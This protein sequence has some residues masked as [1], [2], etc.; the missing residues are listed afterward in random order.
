MNKQAQSLLDYLLQV[1][2]ELKD[3]KFRLVLRPHGKDPN[4]KNLY[5]LWNDAS[6]RIA[7]RKFRR[8]PNMSEAELKSLVSAGLV[9]IHGKELK[10]TSHGVVVLRKMI[11]EDDKFQLGKKAECEECVVKTASVEVSPNTWYK[12]YRDANSSS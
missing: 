6:N 5:G 12:R 10:V 4:A 8:P 11:L 7:D 3:Q 1:M 9:E 2:P